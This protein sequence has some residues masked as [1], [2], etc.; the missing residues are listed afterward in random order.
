MCVFAF[1]A[2]FETVLKNEFRFRDFGF[3]EI[4]KSFYL[5]NAYNQNLFSIKMF[6]FSALQRIDQIEYRQNFPNIIVI[7]SQIS[8]MKLGFINNLVQKF[9][10]KLIFSDKK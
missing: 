2:I 7:R 9:Q 4:L 10:N 1:H 5:A 3:F 6:S 8:Y